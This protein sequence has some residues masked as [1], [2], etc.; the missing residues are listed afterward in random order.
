MINLIFYLFGFSD[1]SRYEYAFWFP[2][3]KTFKGNKI[4]YS[5]INQPITC[6]TII[7]MDEQGNLHWDKIIFS[8]IAFDEYLII[9]YSRI[10]GIVYGK[11]R[12]FFS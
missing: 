2:P 8:L 10:K 3:L 7:L 4:I 9:S 1:S 12:H 5:F 11:I 6:F